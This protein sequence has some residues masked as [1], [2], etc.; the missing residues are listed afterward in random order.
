MALA[1]NMTFLERTISF[2][3]IKVYR[4]SRDQR[5]HLML[6]CY[7]LKIGQQCICLKHYF[8]Q[9]YSERTEEVPTTS[10]KEKEGS[11]AQVLL[12]STWF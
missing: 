8:I 2:Y 6:L 9:T 12:S 7:D 4:K 3:S 5:Q 11:S 1:N 10:E